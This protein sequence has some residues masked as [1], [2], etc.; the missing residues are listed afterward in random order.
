MTEDLINLKKEL[1]KVGVSVESVWDLVNSNKNY[2]QAIP[3]LIDFLRRNSL[4]DKTKEGIIRSLAVK[5][6]K[7]LAG[8]A[9][10]EVFFK[11][12][13][14]KMLLRWTIGNTME[15]VITEKEVKDVLKIVLNKEN[16][17]A[18]QMFIL[19]L[20]KIKSDEVENTL[21]QLLKDDE[22]ILQ[23][24]SALG[25]LK[26]RKAKSKIEKLSNHTNRVVRQEALKALKKI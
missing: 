12:P 10:L 8:T 4:N 3:T 5:S 15:V 23:A 7:G 18:R 14:E 20:G 1:Y 25:K 11:I 9:L 22:V 24:I 13:K 6:A 26:S 16:G 21:I 17:N 2:Q 19:A